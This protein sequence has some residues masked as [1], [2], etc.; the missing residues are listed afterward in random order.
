MMNGDLMEKALE[1]TPQTFLGSVVR[2][3]SS[4][5]DKIRELCLYLPL[6]PPTAKELPAMQKLVRVNGRPSPAGY[7]DLLWRLLNTNEFTLVH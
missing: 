3:K 2:S 5:A 1:I 6:R 4:E 7:Q